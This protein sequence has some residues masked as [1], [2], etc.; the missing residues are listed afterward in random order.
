MAGRQWTR[1]GESMVLDICYKKA[2]V[3]GRE[4]PCRHSSF[5]FPARNLILV[6]PRRETQADGDSDYK[7]EV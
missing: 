6:G 5:L 2:V 7:P 1:H 4:V 3:K